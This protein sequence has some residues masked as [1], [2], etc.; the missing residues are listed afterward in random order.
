MFGKTQESIINL[1]QLTTYEN[2]YSD[3]KYFLVSVMP[4]SPLDYYV[5]Y[6]ALV[7][8]TKYHRQIGLNNRHLFLTVLDAGK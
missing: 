2:K 6:S 5:S 4:K 1:L 3:N 8:I 7:D